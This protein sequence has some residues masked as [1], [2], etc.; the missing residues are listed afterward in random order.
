M[1]SRGKPIVVGRN[2]GGQSAVLDTEQANI[3]SKEGF[4]CRATLW[5]TQEAPADNSVEGDRSLDVK[6]REPFPA[7]MLCRALEILAAPKD[8]KEHLRAFAAPNAPIG[9]TIQ[10]TPPPSPPH[11]PIHPTH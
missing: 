10:P 7:G 1:S 5:G 2:A 8:T 3:Q 6:T 9:Q 11:P 4:F